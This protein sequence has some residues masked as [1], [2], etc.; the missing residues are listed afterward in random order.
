MAHAIEQLQLAS[1]RLSERFNVFRDVVIV[2]KLIDGALY[3][4]LTDAGWVAP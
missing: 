1:R 3:D 2:G 4:V